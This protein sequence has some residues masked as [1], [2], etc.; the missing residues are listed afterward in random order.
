MCEPHDP[1]RTVD[2]PSTPPR[3]ITWDRG[4]VEPAKK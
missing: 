3:R 4:V 1:N 2:V